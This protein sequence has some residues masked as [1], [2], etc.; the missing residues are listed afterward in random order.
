MSKAKQICSFYNIKTYIN[1]SIWINL[2]VLMVSTV[3]SIKGFGT[4]P[5]MKLLQLCTLVELRL[6]PN[7][8]KSKWY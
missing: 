1:R 3:L 8:V 4:F 5:V 6:F 7:N 2:D